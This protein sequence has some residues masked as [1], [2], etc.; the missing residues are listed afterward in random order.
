M[1]RFRIRTLLIVVAFVA[2]GLTALVNASE[3]WWA[4]VSTIALLAFFYAAL[5][6]LLGIARSE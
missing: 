5:F 2:V 1:F 3:M 4:I 6:A